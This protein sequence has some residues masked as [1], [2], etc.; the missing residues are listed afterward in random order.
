MG[1]SAVVPMSTRDE[2]ARMEIVVGVDG[3]DASVGALRQG[4]RFAESLQLPLL[5]IC[6]TGGSIPSSAEAGSVLEAA[7]QRVFGSAPP[8]WF[9][10]AVRAGSP[11]A[12]LGRASEHARMLIIGASGARGL[13]VPRD[14]ASSA[15][16]VAARCPVVIFHATYAAVPA[17]GGTGPGLRP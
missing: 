2:G 5:A 11:A 3:T 14:S 6:A 1:L 17:A 16:A 8:A 15:I 13:P 9:S 7:S 12:V 10:A 4:V